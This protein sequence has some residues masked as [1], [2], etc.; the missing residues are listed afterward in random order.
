MG[1][2]GHLGSC[3]VTLGG[4]LMRMCMYLKTIGVQLKIPVVSTIVRD[5]R[6]T[7]ESTTTIMV[8][9]LLPVVTPISLISLVVLFDWPRHG[10][11]EEE[12][13]CMTDCLTD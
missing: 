10:V 9:Q 1:Q 5:R 11:R 3:P 12:H 2:D 4:L 7:C 8:L 13:D 6:R